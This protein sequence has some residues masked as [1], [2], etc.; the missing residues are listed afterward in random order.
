MRINNFD[1]V[2][3]K[4]QLH[5]SDYL[6]QELSLNLDRNFKC[7]NPAHSDSK[8]SMSLVKPEGIRVYCHGCAASGD[9]FDVCSWT[10]NRPLTGQGF[11]TETL[12]YLADLYGI[13]VEHTELTEDEQYQLDT[14]RAYR[15]AYDYITSWSVEMPEDIK[16]EITR[17]SWKLDS[18]LQEAGVG[19]IVNH[20]AFRNHM[21]G[22][23]FSAGF[24]DDVD[25][26]R[27]DLFSPGHLI[28]TIKD[29]AGRPVGFAARNLLDNDQ[30]KYVNQR[31]TGV[32][33]NIYQKG[34]RLYGLD[35]A[36]RH[37]MEG[38]LYIME[39]Y[40]DVLSCHLNG[41]PRAIA[42]CGTSL[43]ED[44][45][46]L[47][48]EYGIYDIVFCYDSDKPGQQ[49]TE[50]LLDTKF[51]KHKDINVNILTIPG[52]K[53]PDDFIRENGIGAFVDLK[54]T[55]AF[56]WRLYRF[57]ESVDQ[58]AICKRM[59]PLVVSEPSH[60][61]QEKMLQELS[62]F[63]GFNL[64]TLQSELGRL[65]NDKEKVKDRERKFIVEKMNKELESR[66]DQAEMILSEAQNKLYGLKVKY[67]EDSM[68]EESTLKFMSDIKN[69]EELN[70]GSKLGFYLGEDLREFQNALLGDWKDTMQVFGGKANSG[71]TSFLVKLSYE[72]AR[73]DKENNALVIYH[74]IDDSAE[75]LLPKFICVAEGT[76]KLEINHVKNPNYWKQK[77]NDFDALLA[78]REQGYQTVMRLVRDGRLV[79]KDATHG[80]S[81]AYAESL[82]K[83]YTE[84]YPDR[85]IVYVL[86]NFHKLRDFEGL[87]ERIKFKTASQQVKF[88][89]V[90]Y[91]ITA[92]CT[93][94]YTKLPAGMK[95]TNDNIAETVQM[96][97]DANLIAHLWN[98][99]HEKGDQATSDM[100][101]TVLGP[102]GPERR[103]IVEINIGK[104]KI[105]SFKS[106]IYAKFFPA[107]SDFRQHPIDVALAQ[108]EEVARGTQKKTPPRI[109]EG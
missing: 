72:I 88:L 97:Y 78:R 19:Y 35:H 99:M 71:K 34:K 58:E 62:S 31:T 65:I 81:L 102:N 6:S 109:F 61:S 9:I 76:T 37:R 70:D 84:K 24:L 57:D 67:D 91:H 50:E 8:P 68:S 93:M 73:H 29:E 108:Q 85:R 23:G 11:I 63:T 54:P 20:T 98:G 48:K 41:F 80:T 59:M 28:F 2:T 90:T 56:Q 89:A 103:P 79:I 25:L 83:Y 27:K 64:K 14:Y 82:I 92:L 100:F 66:P 107:S 1:D 32:K 55:T 44:H 12:P 52:E 86:D 46:L 42:T 104:N 106:K 16:S 53:D 10:S 69:L 75:Q 33:C 17:R 45:I 21:K 43:T 38:P 47:L 22:L 39:G 105:T 96:E 36:L 95:P 87:E 13:E 60:I 7:L 74:T 3:K 101:H 94:E 4:L 5:L 15:H 49:R 77:M 40:S 30:P 51:A 18:R 26:G